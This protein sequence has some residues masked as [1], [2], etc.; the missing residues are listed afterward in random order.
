[1]ASSDKNTHSGD[2]DVIIDTESLT[3]SG[4][5]P[6]VDRPIP[7]QTETHSQTY[8]EGSAEAAELRSML[9]RDA[10]RAQFGN[11]IQKQKSRAHQMRASEGASAQQAPQEYEYHTD[12]I[13]LVTLIGL[14]AVSLLGWGAYMLFRSSGPDEST[15][16]IVQVADPVASGSTT[17]SPGFSQSALERGTSAM[18]AAESTANPVTD[19]PSDA[20][21]A[22][23]P[24]ISTQEPAT[25]QASTAQPTQA[26]PTQAQPLEKPA[27]VV[28]SPANAAPTPLNA[29]AKPQF[30]QQQTNDGAGQ[31]ATTAASSGE[32]DVILE[33]LFVSRAH[34]ARG[35]ES[36]EPVG[37]YESNSISLEGRNSFRVHWFT[38]FTGLA[39]QALSH[40]W[41]YQDQ[42]VAQ[43]DMNIGSASWRASSNKRVA[44]DSLGQWRVEAVRQ[45]GK[46]LATQHF[47]LVK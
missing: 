26:Q 12:R 6:R 18:S 13:M 2:S 16:E 33:P 45:D 22:G 46:V 40:R 42:L 10:Q 8:P 3:P 20:S 32:S 1:M 28:S 30:E 29:P 36:L 15:Y 43:V 19:M 21:S 39:S 17:A 24:E 37:I 14:L 47:T 4:Q 38:H 34:L 41:Y 11:A 7:G 5:Q 27:N 35:V 31:Q 9:D 23:R 25:A 44:Q